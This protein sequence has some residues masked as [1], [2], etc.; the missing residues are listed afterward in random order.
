[1]SHVSWPVE[2]WIVDGPINQ[3][4]AAYKSLYFVKGLWLLYIVCGLQVQMQ[5]KK[6][7]KNFVFQKE[8]SYI[9]LD[10]FPEPLLE[11]CHFIPEDSG[12]EF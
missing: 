11:S 2:G 8:K 9:N 12:V 1:M 7:K 3:Q 6:K 4:R 5:I 10:K